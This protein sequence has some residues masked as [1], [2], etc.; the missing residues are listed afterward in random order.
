[1]SGVNLEPAIEMWQAGEWCMVGMV[2]AYDDGFYRA[3]FSHIAMEGYPPSRCP[4]LFD[5]IT[6]PKLK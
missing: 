3:K 6:T 2:Y 4:D 1:M 5:K